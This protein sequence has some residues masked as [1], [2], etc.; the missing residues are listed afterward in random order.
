MRIDAFLPKDRGPANISAEV[1]PPEVTARL[2]RRS[3]ETFTRVKLQNVE[4][5]TL[6]GPDAQHTLSRLRDAAARVRRAFRDVGGDV[7]QV[8]GEVDAGPN[9]PTGH[10]VHTIDA[11][12]AAE[13][14][15]VQFKGVPP[16]GSTL[17]RLR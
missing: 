9:V 8:R 5:G 6:D 15:H 12:L 13:I 3:V 10:V 16:P 2:L 17:D 4:I 14:E 11:L 1:T 7:S